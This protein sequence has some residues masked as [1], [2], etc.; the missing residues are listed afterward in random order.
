MA[1]SLVVTLGST[2]GC[3]T[4]IHGRSQ[5]V[6]LASTPPGAIVK[7]DRVQT[8]TPGTITLRRKQDY[9]AVFTKEGFPDRPVKIESKG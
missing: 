9:D 2:S 4:I 7:I 3:A 8:T 6:A 1:I 5:E